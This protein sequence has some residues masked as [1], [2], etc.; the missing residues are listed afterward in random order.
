MLPSPMKAPKL[1]L[2]VLGQAVAVAAVLGL[3]SADDAARLRESGSAVFSAVAA[4]IANVSVVVGI[5]HSLRVKH[6]Q[7]E[8]QP[9]TDGGNDSPPPPVRHSSHPSLGPD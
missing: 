5:L 1:W 6:M 7:T 2:G 8:D 9:A 3:L 4:I